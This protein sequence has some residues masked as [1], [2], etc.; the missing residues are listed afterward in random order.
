MFRI[1]VSFV[2][3]ILFAGVVL[4]DPDRAGDPPKP[5]GPPAPVITIPI[6]TKAPPTHRALKYPLLPDP[7]ELNPG[8]AGPLWLRAGMS[9]SRNPR[10]ITDKEYDWTS[11]ATTALKDL[12]QKEIADILVQYDYPYQL[13]DQAARRSFCDWEYPPLTI[14]SVAH[15]PL[16]EIQ[17]MRQLAWL[18][19]LKHRLQLS[20]GKN[21]DAL[22][23]LQTG[24][25]LARHMNEGRTL[26]Q[27][28]VAIAITAIMLGRVEEMIQQPDAPN[29]YWSLTT[30]PSPFIDARRSVRHEMGTI[31]R[32][33]PALRDL[34]RKKLTQQQVEK[35]FEEVQT[36]LCQGKLIPEGMSK[37]GAAAM[38]MTWHAEAR[39]QLLA[40]GRKEKELDEL[41]PLQVVLL[42]F[43]SDAD[44]VGDE[45]VKWMSVPY[46]QG[47]R[48]LDRLGKEQAK[49][50]GH[51]IAVL[52]GLLIPAMSKVYDAHTRTDR[53]IVS[54]R[55]V[56]AIRLYAAKN[57]GKLPAKLSDI[58][59]VP[60]PLDPVTGKGF[61][62]YY[63]A[64][65]DRAAF[66]VPPAP[67]HPAIL[68]RR[69]EFVPAK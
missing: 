58:K 53:L 34:E 68:G 6:P 39:K 28:L 13:S 52:V 10:K 23:T 7:L 5:A 29:L 38:V 49:A 14:K 25:A 31:R 60:L 50:K 20:E 59:D 2:L 54:L 32:S 17:M 8:N 19:T 67:G 4:A 61:D 40:Q 41:P 21:D 66:E 18:L 24:F 36:E 1:L 45:V 42:Y 15:L 27:D 47:A 35:L 56:E 37:L 43:L 11:P 22:H 30:L 64:K 26:I 33:I 44:R 9:A 65:D 48:E 51:P 46:W 3:V 55:V 69:Y 12:P 62:D 57:G 16:D 63:Q